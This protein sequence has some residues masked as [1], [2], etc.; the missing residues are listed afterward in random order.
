MYN[1]TQYSYSLNTILNYIEYIIQADQELQDWTEDV[2]LNGLHG[3]ESFPSCMSTLDQLVEIATSI[4]FNTS[5]RNAAH[6]NGM[7]DI[8]G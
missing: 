4:L 1:I 5:C 3:N 8:Y 6:T 7:M 2:H